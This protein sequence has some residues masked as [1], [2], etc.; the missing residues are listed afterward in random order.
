MYGKPEDYIETAEEGQNFRG[1][2]YRV[3]CKDKLFATHH[4]DD[5]EDARKWS[6]ECI[7]YWVKQDGRVDNYRGE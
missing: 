4:S 1:Y 7:E 2:K 5:Y 3:L 6:K